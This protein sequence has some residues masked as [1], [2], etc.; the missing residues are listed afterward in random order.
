MAQPVYCTVEDVK[1]ALDQKETARND[2]QLSRAIDS[3]SRLIEN[4]CHRKFYPWT[5]T[6]YF[7]WP[8]IADLTP[9][10]LY[11][12]ANELTSVTAVTAGGTAVTLGNVLLEPNDFGPPY[13][14]LEVNRS[15]SSAFSSGSTPQR[16]IAVTGTFGYSDDTEAAGTLAAAVASTSATTLTVSDSSLIGTGDT[17][18][19]DSERMLVTK[20]AM[21]T[22]GQTGSL[23][24]SVADVTLAVATGSAY[25]PGEILLLD[26]ERVLVVDVSGNNLTVKR[27]WDGSVLAVH[28][29]ATIYAPRLLTVVRG[30]TGTTAATHLISAAITRQTVPG[31]VRDLTIALA[32]NRYLQEV[33]GYARNIIRD[34]GSNSTGRSL[35]KPRTR[36][37][38]GGAIPE[39]RLNVL[40][41]YGRTRWAAV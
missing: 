13:A 41:N 18:K 35:S 25:S 32:M 20:R 31:P 22:T 36:I 11:L 37:Y 29:T 34:D 12:E 5:G 4:D 16:A 8:N 33:S 7:D 23:T 28:T 38:L 40:N 15:T 19:V 6:R 39:L 3:A 17:I 21:T 24:A 1:H 27:A 26:S 14:W 9:W 30:L 10:R 2:A